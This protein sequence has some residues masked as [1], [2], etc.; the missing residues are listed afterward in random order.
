M[1]MQ[2]LGVTVGGLQVAVLVGVFFRL[3]SF[4]AALDALAHRVSNLERTAP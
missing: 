3:G 1:D 2:T 4:S